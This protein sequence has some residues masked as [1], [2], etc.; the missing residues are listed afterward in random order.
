MTFFFFFKL[1]LLGIRKIVLVGYPK[2]Y[3]VNKYTYASVLV[4]EF[5][6]K[7]KVVVVCSPVR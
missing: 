7:G 1:Y 6:M 3:M 5:V 2:L 4:W